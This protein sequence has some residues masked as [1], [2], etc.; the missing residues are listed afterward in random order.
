M[1]K[2]LLF[3]VLGYGVLF[4][5]LAGVPAIQGVFSKSA[6]LTSSKESVEKVSTKPHREEQNAKE[7]WGNENLEDNG[8]ENIKGVVEKEKTQ[9]IE[10][11]K[12]FYADGT[13]SSILRFKKKNLNGKQVFFYQDG[14][15]WLEADF[16]EG[17]CISLKAVYPNGKIWWDYGFDKGFLNGPVKMFYPSGN[18]WVEWTFSKGVFQLNSLKVYSES[19]E[20]NPYFAETKSPT[21]LESKDNAQNKAIP[22]AASLGASTQTQTTYLSGEISSVWPFK[23]GLLQGTVFLLKEKIVWRE[24][25]FH[26]GGPFD[27]MRDYYASEALWADWKWENLSW[28][29]K[30]MFFYESGKLWAQF[31]FQ[32]GFLSKVEAF[33]ENETHVVAAQ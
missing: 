27:F 26:E 25:F 28:A 32:Q 18:P 23:E 22:F 31:T 10:E 16:Q 29:G 19:G 13:P 12:T 5:L 3:M 2:F 15:N 20:F 30:Q 7:K 17:V 11:L 9:K 24:I 1:K 8:V 6:S 21:A 4:F 14:K 33:S